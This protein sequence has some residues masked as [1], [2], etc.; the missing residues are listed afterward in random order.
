MQIFAVKELRLSR[1]V[2][3]LKIIISRN[4]KKEILWSKEES[5]KYVGK[6][7]HDLES[8]KVFGVSKDSMI[9]EN[10]QEKLYRIIEKLTLERAEQLGIPRRTYFDWKKKIREGKPVILK[11]KLKIKLFLGIKC[12]FYN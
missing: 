9:Y 7:I 5:I 6:E 12:I 4:N 2:I 3:E 1:M 11:T 10:E 8:S